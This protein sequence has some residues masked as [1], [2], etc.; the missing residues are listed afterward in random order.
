MLSKSI[1]RFAGANWGVLVTALILDVGALLFFPPLEPPAWP[2]IFGYLATAATLSQAV[3]V[4]ITQ[5]LTNFAAPVVFGSVQDQLLQIFFYLLGF[6]TILAY[7]V[8]IRYLFRRLFRPP[9]G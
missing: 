1:A 5:T 2:G 7:V 4:L 8:I 9:H 6:V 3:P